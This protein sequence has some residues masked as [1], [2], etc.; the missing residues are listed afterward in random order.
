[1]EDFKY[2]DLIAQI[3]QDIKVINRFYLYSIK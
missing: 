1:M 2:L 3:K